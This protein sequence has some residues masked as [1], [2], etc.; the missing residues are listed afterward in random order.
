M[1][2]VVCGML[3]RRGNSRAI[4]FSA[5]RLKIVVLNRLNLLNN[6]VNMITRVDICQT[7]LR[8][9]P[10]IISIQNKSYHRFIRNHL[11]LQTCSILKLASAVEEHSLLAYWPNVKIATFLF[12]PFTYLNSQFLQSSFLKKTV[13]VTIWTFPKEDHRST[14]LLASVDP[15]GCT[16]TLDPSDT[17]GASRADG[18]SWPG[19]QL[20]ALPTNELSMIVGVIGGVWNGVFKVSVFIQTLLYSCRL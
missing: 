10:V 13:E 17:P 8:L 16:W 3:T 20:D 19:L 1:W 11:A 2:Y 5:H 6:C 4:Y 9:L 15:N 18:I 7:K 12:C 14:S